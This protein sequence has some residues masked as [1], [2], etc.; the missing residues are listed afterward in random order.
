M[1]RPD[2]AVLGQDP[3]FG[4]G[5]RAQTEAFW[6][7]ATELGRRPELL[8]LAHPSL[9][10]R[11]PGPVLPRH[12]DR[13]PL[14]LLDGMSQVVG[15]RRLGSRLHGA[16][17]VWVV[18]T[19]ASY[20]LAAARAH[21]R[22]GCWIGTSLEDEWRSRRGG[23]PRSRRFALRLNAPILRRVE[24]NVLRRAA[25]VFAT[26]PASQ[27]AVAEA[28]GLSEESVA[29]LPI[30]VDTEALS[31]APDA[32]WRAGLEAPTLVF[33]G[34]ADDPRKNVAL[35]LD[36]W[37]PI[38]RS[39]PGATLR[40]VGRPPRGPLP[41]GVVAVGEAPSVAAE[42]RPA[43]LFVLPSLQEGFGI[44]AAEAL[45][46]G[47][48]VVTTPSGGPEDLV[49]R[50]AGGVVLERHDPSELTATVTGLL[51]DPA[52]LSAMRDRGRAHVER[53]HSP[54]RFRE[55]LALALAEVAP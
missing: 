21:R 54:A 6:R 48:P 30:P 41:A 51:A 42:L 28:A 35:L 40:L 22:Y 45:A 19:V 16:R 36:A 50:S 34:R 26:S 18:A 39:F 15:A 27:R 5:A 31:P 55:R 13:A 17:A 52:R 20:G 37:E 23:L 29:L 3:R 47:V 8:Y 11:D 44:A 25:R 4:G 7:G 2:L 49:R 10:G 9:A 38:R 33:V 53:E 24:R 46:C 1:T 43:T 32:E 12:G 14:P